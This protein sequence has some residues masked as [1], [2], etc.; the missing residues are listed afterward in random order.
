MFGVLY[1]VLALVTALDGL[2]LRI[3]AKSPTHHVSL[4]EMDK[5]I[6]T[7]PPTKRQTKA[8]D[9]G[10]HMVRCVIHIS[11]FTLQLITT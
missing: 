6:I 11:P 10:R 8:L 7:A 2:R 4:G 1:P 5:L 3:A 9:S